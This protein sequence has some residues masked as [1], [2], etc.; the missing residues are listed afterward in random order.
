MKVA[1]NVMALKKQ[2]SDLASSIEE[3]MT[4]NAACPSTN[5]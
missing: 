4:S 1:L 5:H 2:T 3:A